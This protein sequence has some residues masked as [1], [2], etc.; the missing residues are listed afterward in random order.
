M[1]RAGAPDSFVPAGAVNDERGA[2][3]AVCCARVP[4]VAVPVGAAVGAPSSS[5]DV[6]CTTISGA[7]S[8]HA[9]GVGERTITADEFCAG[10]L[11]VDPPDLAENAFCT[12]VLGAAAAIVEGDAI[13][14]GDKTGDS[15]WTGSPAAIQAAGAADGACDAPTGVVSVGAVDAGV[16]APV[17]RDDL[18]TGDWVRVAGPPAGAAICVRDITV[19]VF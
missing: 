19:D 6:Y 7:A 14:S 1:L 15:I 12:G 2:V 18:A 13:G 17:V 16:S 11:Y 4:S 8:G 10:P 9:D 3:P 5:A